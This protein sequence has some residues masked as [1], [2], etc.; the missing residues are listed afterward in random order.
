M[1][2]EPRVFEILHPQPPMKQ[3]QILLPLDSDM[4]QNEVKMHRQMEI[5]QETSR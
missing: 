1:K 4:S 3:T 5:N 2:H